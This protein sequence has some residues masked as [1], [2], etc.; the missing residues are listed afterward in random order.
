MPEYGYAGEILRVDLSSRNVSRFD[1][2][3]YTDRFL[4]GRG[5]ASKL[6]WDMVAPETTAISPNNCLICASGPVTGFFGLAG[7][8]WIIGGKSPSRR[9]EA[10]SYGNLGGKWGAA[11]KYAGY[12][13]L[14]VQGKADRPVYLYI[15]DDKVEIRDASALWGKSAFDATDSIHEELGKGVCVLTIGPAAE[16][17]VVFATALADGG[18]SVSGGMGS[19]MGSKNLK[20]IAVAGDR[21]P[22]A[23]S[24][25][26]LQQLVE[27]LRQIRGSALEVPS[28]WRVAGI[29]VKE[30]CYGCGIG[31]SRHGY[32]G[33]KGRRYKSFCQATGVYS[34]P[35]MDY[36]GKWNEVQLKAIQL[37][38]GYGLDTAVLAPLILWLIECFREGLI[39]EAETGLPF[40]KAGSQEFIETLTRK[41]SLREGFGDILARGTREAAETL[42]DRAKILTSKYVSTGTNEN[43]DYDPRLIL[44][45]ALLLATEP[46]KPVAQLHGISGNVLIT[47]TNY[48]RGMKEAFFTTEALREA[49]AK[50]WGGP[51]AVD[52]S[53]YEGK[54][55]AAKKVQD[56][57]YA[58]ESLILCDLHWP[59]IVANYGGSLVGDPSIESQI[60]SAITGQEIDE[61]GLSL[62]GERIGNLQRATL[63]RQGWGGRDGDRILD[64][65]HTEP[66]K[67][68]EV[69]FNPDG[70]MPGK[71]GQIFS[72]LGTVVERDSF[73]KMKSDYYRLRGWDEIT[74]FPTRK[75]LEELG[76]RDIAADLEKRG[77][78]G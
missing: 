5:V 49:A 57:S 1:S 76:L 77:L 69:F 16:N 54:A 75:K 41:I 61:A 22:T 38:D 14:A 4:G 35:V 65:F 44:T 64:Y 51:L 27:W 50:F 31:C 3:D 71:D 45:T 11:L 28:P 39:S 10:F 56:R 78:L 19:I 42:G 17:M 60:L 29:T 37:C 74:G 7:C 25:E 47:W 40:S 66:L 68:G 2:S 73:E 48:A 55:L 12:D 8:R 21:R 43:K 70:L 34:K 63:L 15:H 23:A 20:A 26:K 62:I 67:K 32:P 13:A 72:R 18:A 46:R 36:F 30:N 53:T 59:M 52:F 6:Y 58:Q 33:E 9:P 24:P